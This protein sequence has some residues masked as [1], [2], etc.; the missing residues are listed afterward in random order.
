MKTFKTAKGFLKH[1]S[2][3]AINQDM[4]DCSDWHKLTESEQKHFYGILAD[5]Q[6]DLGEIES[7]SVN[8]DYLKSIY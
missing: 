4:S 2:F 7:L 1:L 8:S 5:I 6:N 3:L